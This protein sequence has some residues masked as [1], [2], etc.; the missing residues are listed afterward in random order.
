MAPH[1][2]AP[3]P[4]AAIGRIL[5]RCV[6]CR[7]R[8][9]R[10]DAFCPVT[11]ALSLERGA[12]WRRHLP[13]RIRPGATT[14]NDLFDRG[15][16]DRAKGHVPR[17]GIETGSQTAALAPAVRTCD[18]EAGPHPRGLVSVQPAPHARVEGLAP[19]KGARVAS[20]EVP[21]ASGDPLGPGTAPR[22]SGA[23]RS[24]VAILDSG[25]AARPSPPPTGPV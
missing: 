7:E 4:I 18:S 12:T 19:R 11:V 15:H 1:P 2:S 13:I 21:P 23:V 14:L 25:A 10:S 3:P 6:G 20:E 24:D 9:E 16:E 22:L 17:P 5:P 8:M